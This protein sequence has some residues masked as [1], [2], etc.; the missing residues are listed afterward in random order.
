[1]PKNCITLFRMK[2]VIRVFVALFGCYVLLFAGNLLFFK[3][4][5]DQSALPPSTEVRLPPEPWSSQ[6]PA[7]WPQIVLT[8]QASFRQRT[9]LRGASAFLMEADGRTLGATAQHLLGENGG[10]QPEAPVRELDS[11]LESWVL[12]PRT[13]RDHSVNVVGLGAMPGNDMNYDWL[14]LRLRL[15]NAALPAT[16]LHLRASP[17][18][19]VNRFT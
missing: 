6:P 10:V 3:K 5:G 11:L 18:P 4:R 12:H 8:N 2:S 9:P 7:Q 13:L 19:W 16:P 1:M 17:C 15:G 14:L